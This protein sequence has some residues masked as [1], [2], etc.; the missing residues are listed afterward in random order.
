MPQIA[1]DLELF[2]VG[3]LEE[4][5]PLQEAVLALIECPHLFLDTLLLFEAVPVQFR[6][7]QRAQLLLFGAEEPRQASQTSAR[8]ERR[9][10][11]WPFQ[12]RAGI[13]G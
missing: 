1:F 2:E 11:R 9:S 7:L 8:P 10:A 3:A 6:L 13:F 12:R 4:V 5:A